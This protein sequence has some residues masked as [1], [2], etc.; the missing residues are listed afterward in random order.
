MAGSMRFRGYIVLLV[1][2]QGLKGAI[3][4]DPTTPAAL[5]ARQGLAIYFAVLILSSGIIE[6]LIVRHGDPMSDH[7]DL[8]L[9]LMWMPALSSAVAR[10]ALREGIRD[11]SFRF[12]GKIGFRSIGFAVLMPLIVGT[13]AYGIAWTAG[14]VGFSAITPSPAELAMSPAAARL[15][16]MEPISRFV[17][18]VALGATF[19]TIFGCLWAAGEE[20]GWRGYMLTRLIAA[21]VPQPLFVSG[22]IWAVWHFPLI[23]SGVYA[24]GPYPLLSAGLFIFTTMGIALVAG[25]LRLRSGSVWPAIVLHAAWN[26]VIQ[27]PF[28][29]SSVGAGATLWVGE[30][31][32]LVAVTTLIVGWI[33]YRRWRNDA[34]RST[35]LSGALHA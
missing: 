28:D 25:V 31:G 12:G 18:S 23:L 22:L 29:R 13:I 3:V 30:S 2:H 11:V 35:C 20:I 27:N 8:V 1:R 26:S 6:W 32:V 9:V 17:A 33:V 4:S 7:L 24:S 14:L 15:A 19:F 16:A 10:L 5:K 21:G 34:S